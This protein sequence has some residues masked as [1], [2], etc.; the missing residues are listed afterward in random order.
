MIIVT[1]SCSKNSFKKKL[2][3]TY[4]YVFKFFRFE[5]RFRKSYFRDGFSVDYALR[6]AVELKLCFQIQSGV[7]WTL[8][9]KNTSYRSQMKGKDTVLNIQV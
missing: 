4:F 5:G 8:L 2:R 9:K 7:V 3:F 1:L 6:L